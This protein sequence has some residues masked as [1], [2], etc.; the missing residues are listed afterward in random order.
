M[1]LLVYANDLRVD[2]ARDSEVSRESREGVLPEAALNNNLAD[3]LHAAGHHEESMKHLRAAVTIFA[4]IGAEAG[5]LEPQ[6]WKLVE[7]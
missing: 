7:W 1:P 4:E 2:F 5:E 6:I 3:L